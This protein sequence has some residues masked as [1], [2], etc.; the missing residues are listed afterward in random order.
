MLSHKKG[1]TD[2]FN[3]WK[4]VGNKN[5]HLQ[6]FRY[7]VYLDLDY[8]LHFQFL[9]FLTYSTIPYAPQPHKIPGRGMSS[10]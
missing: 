3:Y 4:A 7:T 8:C 2:N 10:V 5:Y 9:A 1:Q 6:Q